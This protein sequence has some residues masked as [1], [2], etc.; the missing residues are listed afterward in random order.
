LLAIVCFKRKK[1]KELL[2]PS[3]SNESQLDFRTNLSMK[4]QQTIGMNCS[5]RNANLFG[6]AIVRKG[7]SVKSGV[8]CPSEPRRVTRVNSVMILMLR[9]HWRREKHLCTFFRTDALQ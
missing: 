2:L 1:L 6:Y 3:A 8:R 4:Q 9:W 7:S 5:E